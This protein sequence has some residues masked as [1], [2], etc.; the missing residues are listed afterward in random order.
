MRSSLSLS[1]DP[2]NLGMNPQ[3]GDVERMMEGLMVMGAQVKSNFTTLATAGQYLEYTIIPPDYASV[4]EVT[5]PGERFRIG[6]SSWAHELP[7]TTSLV[8]PFHYRFRS[9]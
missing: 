5:Q 2:A 6:L 9:T 3:T 1:I 8:R 4:S 7:S